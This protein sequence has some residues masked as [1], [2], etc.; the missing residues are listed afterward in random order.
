MKA[1]AFD[2][3]L[4]LESLFLCGIKAGDYEIGYIW[5]N[6]KNIKKLQLKSCESVGDFSSF[7]GFLRFSSGLQELELRTCRSIV[8]VVVLTLAESSLSLDSLLIYD[9]GSKE[10][11]LQFINQSNSSLRKL[12]LRLPL[13]LDNSHLIALSENLN[14]RSLISLRLQ[15]CC[16]VTGEGLKA[17]GRAI[18]NDLEELTLINC[19][20][21]EGEP[22]LLTTLGQ[23]LKKL[24]KLDLSYNDMLLDKE[25]V[26]MLISCNHLV[27]LR[28]RGCGRLTNLAFASVAKSCKHLQHVDITYCKSID[29]EGVENFVLNSPRLRLVEVEQGKISEATRAW[30]SNRFIEVVS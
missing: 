29:V 9:G 23:N 25:L 6:C 11:L 27:E 10:G 21:V 15:S 17:L 14:F 4:K 8:D 28:L 19:D 16:L 22:G 2:A 12:D 3:E 1:D 13:D 26:S 5:K 7:S 30:A 24:R 20:V 18:S